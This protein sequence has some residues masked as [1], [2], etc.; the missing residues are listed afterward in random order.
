MNSSKI[1]PDIDPGHLSRR[2]HMLL[3]PRSCDSR[4]NSKQDFVVQLVFVVL[5]MLGA[6]AGRGNEIPGHALH[7]S[8]ADAALPPKKRFMTFRVAGHSHGFRLCMI[9]DENNN[10]QN[11]RKNQAGK[12]LC[13]HLV[14]QTRIILPVTLR[15]K[16]LVHYVYFAVVRMLLRLKKGGCLF[17]KSIYFYN[18]HYV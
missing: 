5:R 7:G 2:R 8:I 10:K 18:Y 9:Y 13:T 15:I 6:G 11:E 16:A 3:I 14:Y 17:I 1:V 4:L 12:N